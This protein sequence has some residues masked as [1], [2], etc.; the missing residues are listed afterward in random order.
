MKKPPYSVYR[1]LLKAI[2]VWKALEGEC[3]E[4]L[5]FTAFCLQFDNNPS[6][7]LLYLSGNDRNILKNLCLQYPDLML[8]EMEQLKKSYLYDTSLEEDKGVERDILFS[9]RLRQKFYPLPESKDQA[10]L[11]YRLR[12]G[13]YL[14]VLPNHR[15]GDY[16]PFAL[17]GEYLFEDFL[18]GLL[19]HMGL[20]DLEAWEYHSLS[21]F[22]DKAGNEYILLIDGTSGTGKT[23]STILPVIRDTPT[24]SLSRRMPMQCSRPGA[25][26]K[27]R[28]RRQTSLYFISS[29]IMGTWFPLWN[30]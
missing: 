10:S 9:K 11:Q 15:R 12:K 18:R 13:M 7:N 8:D 21:S 29:A 26:A 25:S 6:P 30:T 5:S 28:L 4:A 20:N 16:L 23:S 1:I 22:H 2:R 27:L 19:F 17:Q 14:Y 24:W 3:G